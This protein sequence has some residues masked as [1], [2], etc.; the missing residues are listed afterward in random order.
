[1]TSEQPL[2]VATIAADDL[3]LDALGQ[4][5]RLEQA[6]EVAAMLA[7]WRAD[8]D[9]DESAAGD[10]GVAAPPARIRRVR[11]LT[12]LAV[13]AALLLVVGGGLTVAASGA[14]PG[15]PLWPITQV[16]FP[17]QAHVAAAQDAIDR[18]RRAAAEGRRDDA[19]RLV[20]E[21]DGLI[22]K[23]T[24]PADAQRL[25]AELDEVRRLLAG[26]PV[27]V[28][29]GETTPSVAPQPPVGGGPGGGTT[30]STPGGGDGRT[31]PGGGLPTV[32]APSPP[33]L[34]LPSL[35]L[36]SLPHL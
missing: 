8:L 18:A 30:G 14:K 6:D 33:G 15:S 1:M 29:R 22:G 23:V 25:R 10:A 28:P 11:P 36:P 34:P 20:D 4:G 13:A 3:L 31:K 2:D 5:R 35:P 19:Q 24:S 9:G 26:L 7:A 21:A 16:V 27:T 32:P 12:R 17:E